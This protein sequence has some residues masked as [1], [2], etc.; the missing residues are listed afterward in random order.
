MVLY[1]Y[2]IGWIP[3]YVEISSLS[4][5][6]GSFRD[7]W[8]G[9]QEIVIHSLFAVQKV[10]PGVLPA[11]IGRR[12]ETWRVNEV[13]FKW[14]FMFFLCMQWWVWILWYITI[15]LWIGMCSQLN[16]HLETYN[17]LSLFLDDLIFLFFWS[18][19]VTRVCVCTIH[20]YVCYIL[21][22]YTMYMVNIHKDVANP[23]GFPFRKW[24]T[25]IVGVPH[26]L[27]C[28]QE[29]KSPFNDVYHVIII[30]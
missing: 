27:I 29:G 11:P 7:L 3:H 8:N 25:F 23:R 4:I 18:C 14:D 20:T 17:Y 22:Y 9:P 2:G 28:L 26:F 13:T 12:E 5:R 30:H 6:C 21:L 10:G 15:W 16:S 24:S 19:S 1:V